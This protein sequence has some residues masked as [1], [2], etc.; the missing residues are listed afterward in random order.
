MDNPAGGPGRAP[1]VR[2][3]SP[4]L[5]SSQPGTQHMPTRRDFLAG[6]I[7]AGA[8]MRNRTSLARPAASATPVNFEVPAG[9]CDCHPHI[10]GDP[11]KFPYF[12]GR[13]YTPE[14]AHPDEM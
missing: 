3:P 14:P 4:R 1:V 2:H 7:A 9:S 13:T 8:I 5:I 11:E 10:F 6:T 12:P